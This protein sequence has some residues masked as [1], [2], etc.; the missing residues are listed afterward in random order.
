MANRWERAI[1]EVFAI[2]MRDIMLKANLFVKKVEESGIK[3]NKA[4]LFGSYARGNPKPYSDIDVCI[5]SPSL[6][7]DFVKEMVKLG[8]ISQKIDLRIE[9]IPFNPERLND[10]YDPLA[11]EVRKNGILLKE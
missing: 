7:Y 8:K 5:V 11:F 1:P 9:P 4:F 2:I 6:G 3:V 10:P